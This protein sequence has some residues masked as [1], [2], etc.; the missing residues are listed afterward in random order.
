MC[1][2]CGVFLLDRAAQADRIVLEKMNRTLIH[3]GPDD[4]GYLVS[5]PVGLAMRRLSIID[6][7]TGHQPLSNEYETIWIVYNGETYNYPE[8]R[9]ELLSRG[10]RFKTRSDTE[11]I[12]HLYEEYAEDCVMRLNGMFAFALWDS[13]KQR[14]FLARDRDAA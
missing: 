11:V 9:A 5:G 12:V 6:L 7:E 3:R 1:G 13:I 4:E 2:I 8:L 14:L 10:H